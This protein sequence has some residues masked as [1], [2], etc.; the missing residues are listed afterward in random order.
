VPE[1]ERERERG[2]YF[3][4]RIRHRAALYRKRSCFLYATGKERGK[5]SPKE[6]GMVTCPNAGPRGGAGA[7]LPAPTVTVKRLTTV[8]T[9]LT[10]LAPA[11]AAIIAQRGGGE[12]GEEKEERRKRRER[13]EMGQVAVY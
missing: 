11:R 12:R 3:L 9:P 13:R 2:A 4:K 6:R 10:A 7:A 8:L 5:E 1:R